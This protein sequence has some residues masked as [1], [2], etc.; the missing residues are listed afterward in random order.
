M[1]ISAKRIF[2][3]CLLTALAGCA[4][5]EVSTPNP[6]APAA[7]VAGAHWR[8]SDD[9]P[10]A[11]RDGY[12]PPARLAVLLPL[13]GQLATAGGSVRD[14][15][16]AGYSGERRQ[17]PELVFY[18]TAGTAAGALAAYVRALSDGADQILGPLGR[19]EITALLQRS[20][21][22]PLLA[23]NS[24]DAPLPINVASF[25]LSPEGEGAAIADYLAARN[26]SRVLVLSNGDDNAV[27]AIDTLRARLETAGGSIVD[28]VAV[29]GDNP[30]DLTDRFRASAAR[31][32]GIDATVLALRGSQARLVT[33][34]LSAAGLGQRLRIATSQI[35]SG[36]GK[37]EEDRALDGIVFPGE[38][39]IVAGAT[40]LPAAASLAGE[41]PTARGPAARL[42]AFGYD[43]WLL[44]GW[45]QH[46]AT[47]PDATLAGATGTLRLDAE[48]NVART[49]AWAI[50][51]NGTAVA[52]PGG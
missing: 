52:Q 16:L 41:L 7:P 5:V 36:T 43:A 1:R 19:E 32:G 39:W 26:A 45:L 22:V 2:S 12:R 20:S 11:E 8:F 49:P 44:S 46:L 29:V 25:S 42:F 31:E 48:G 14:G 17:R 35:T 34:Q 15:L 3:A 10:A 47:H 21:T 40:A 24:A 37:A 38:A 27:R 13:T 50:W 28:T 18:D 33:P 51:S 9:R 30:G 23:L 6:Q 4:T